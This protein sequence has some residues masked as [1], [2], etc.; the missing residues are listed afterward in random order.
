MQRLTCALLHLHCARA[1][2]CAAC[3]RFATDEAKISGWRKEV[4]NSFYR[5]VLNHKD[6]G[7]FVTF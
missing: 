5:L 2:C 4:K 3:V 1:Q 7:I 6:Q